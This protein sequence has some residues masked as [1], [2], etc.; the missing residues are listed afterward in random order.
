MANK[1]WS[2]EDVI[3]YAQELRSPFEEQ[4]QGRGNMI[5]TSQIADK[6][7]QRMSTRTAP[8]V[9]KNTQIR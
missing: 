3:Q 7:R 6:I 5:D 8:T 1:K 4:T 2:K 9:N